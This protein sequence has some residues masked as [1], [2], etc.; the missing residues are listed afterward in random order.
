[1]TGSQD[2]DA[3]AADLAARGQ[4]CAGGA[5]GASA[6][7]GHH[8]GALAAAA[9]SAGR[10]EGG[11]GAAPAVPDVVA[12]Q[13][14][15]TD[16]MSARRYGAPPATPEGDAISIPRHL[17][18]IWYDAA[19]E[20]LQECY[21]WLK[22]KHGNH[23][24]AAGLNFGE[25]ERRRELARL[26]FLD[27]AWLSGGSD[28]D[29]APDRVASLPPQPADLRGEKLQALLAAS[30][31]RLRTT[32]MRLIDATN[33]YR[34]TQ[35][36]RD[37]AREEIATLKRTYNQLFDACSAEQARAEKAE[38]A[39]E[40]GHCAT[41][42]TAGHYCFGQDDTGPD[43]ADWIGATGG[44]ACCHACHKGGAGKVRAL[45]EQMDAA[46]IFVD[47][48]DCA[49]GNLWRE[50]R[51]ALQPGDGWQGSARSADEWHEDMGY[52]VWWSWTGTEW[53]GEPAWI[54]SPNCS[55]WPGYHTHF[56]PHP[57][58]PASLPQGEETK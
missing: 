55:D 34:M 35:V 28:L 48:D 19:G 1:M 44:K 11:A 51:A 38:A 9:S 27:L 30:D 52:C 7:P 3:G 56:T 49:G 33:A 31:D 2:N 5:V 20:L 26:L 46:A 36:E 58:M 40:A 12:D 41:C 13:G 29:A 8:P 14:A 53:A 50:L 22:L 37:A 25:T 4:G 45:V 47:G 16:R 10:A 15:V 42:G 18:S 17:I 24:S 32:E 23:P 54:G 43:H 39:R 21:D 57:D 6:I